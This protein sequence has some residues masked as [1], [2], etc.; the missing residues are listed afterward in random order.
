MKGNC[1]QKFRV[2]FLD[3][4]S[5][6]HARFSQMYYQLLDIKHVYNYKDCI[7]ALQEEKFHTIYLDH[8]LCIEDIL[9]SPDDT[10]KEKTGTD[11][12]NWM[13]SNLNPNTTAEVIVH[14]LNP[15]GAQRMVSILNEAG[16]EAICY[17][18]TLFRRVH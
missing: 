11:V 8:D 3:D 13:V 2:L 4:M 18:F 12:C 9:V 10:S 5:E 7:K 17:P 6:R 1:M 15:G 16:F 14:S